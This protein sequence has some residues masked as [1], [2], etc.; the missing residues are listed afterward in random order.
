MNEARSIIAVWLQ[1]MKV[2]NPLA[3]VSI[4]GGLYGYTFFITDPDILNTLLGLGG[5]SI[6]ELSAGAMKIIAGSSYITGAIGFLAS[7][8][9]YKDLPEN[10]ES[11]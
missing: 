2:Q 7:S 8:S 10:K 1:K 11:I 9:T 4:I 5:K 6:N 3:F